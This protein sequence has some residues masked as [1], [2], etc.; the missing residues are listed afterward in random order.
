MTTHN[1]E[2][3]SRVVIAHSAAATWARA[4]EEWQVVSMIQDP[5]ESG[6]CV[7]GKT[8]LIY[9]YTIRNTR[10]ATDL[11]PIGSS[12]VELFEVEEL[13]VSVNVLRRLLELRIA[14]EAGK[15]IELTSKHFSRAMLADLYEN[16]AFPPNDYNR[17]NGYNDYKF[18]LDMFNQHHDFTSNENKKVWVLINRTIRTFVLDDPR[19][20]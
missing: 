18:L 2:T 15:Q 13:D 10:T 20:G 6:V 7:C 14:F 5:T 1:F 16:G 8:G 12:C 19:L 3:L 9:L 4:V 11:F 17:S